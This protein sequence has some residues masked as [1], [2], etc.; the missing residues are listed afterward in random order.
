MTSVVFSAGNEE[1]AIPVQY[2]ISIE[3]MEEIN[4]IPHLPSYVRGVVRSRDELIPVLD[5]ATILY[6]S[7][8]PMN[9]EARLLVIQTK[10]FSYG[11]AVHD[12]KEIL[13]I[14][15]EALQQVGLVAYHK[16]KYFSSIANLQDRLI[17]MI[18]PD[19]LLNVLD[20]VKEIRNY[21]IELQQEA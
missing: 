19:E 21:M 4:P 7:A 16:T 18:D 3:K 17:T 14:P 15:S 6:E 12:A 2:I 9:M 11:L 8:T 5:L 13:E 1:Y 20:G 10:E